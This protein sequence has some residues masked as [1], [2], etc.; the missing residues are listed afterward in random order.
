VENIF[1]VTVLAG[2]SIGVVHER[3]CS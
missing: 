2:T 3:E 1:C